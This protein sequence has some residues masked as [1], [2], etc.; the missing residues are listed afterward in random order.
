M[1]Y[2]NWK[3]LR[4][5]GTQRIWKLWQS[6][7]SIQ[8]KNL[9][10]NNKISK[11]AETVFHFAY[12]YREKLLKY[13]EATNQSRD[14]CSSINHVEAE[15]TSK[16]QQCPPFPISHAKEDIVSPSQFPVLKSLEGAC[17][18]RVL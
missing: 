3:T 4:P 10:F 14:L 2:F 8:K 13:S 12:E 17:F 5:T 1:C 15:A 7:C 16:R 9:T 6:T 11:L 18:I